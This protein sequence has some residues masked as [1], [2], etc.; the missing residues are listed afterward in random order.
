MEA[1]VGLSQV[2]QSNAQ[3]EILAPIEVKVNQ[4]LR[5]ELSLEE[6]AAELTDPEQW[7]RLNMELMDYSYL[8]FSVCLS[9]AMAIPASSFYQARL[10]GLLRAI[11]RRP[12]PPE[13]K[14]EEPEIW[15]K[16]PDFWMQVSEIS[17]RKGLFENDGESEPASQKMSPSEWANLHSFI[18]NWQASNANAGSE[19]T[20]PGTYFQALQLF[21]HVLE[22]PRKDQTIARNLPAVAAWILSSAGPGLRL[23]CQRNLGLGDREFTRSAPWQDHR[24]GSGLDAS[25]LYR[26]PDTWNQ[27][28]WNFWATRLQEMQGQ[29]EL[30]P[31][32][33]GAARL[34]LE[35]MERMEM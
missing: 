18:A 13:A 15:A 31:E 24:G 1:H 21:R 11:Q 27:E 6:A 17:N 29:Q 2:A 32:A 26:G 16:M 30:G 8:L 23:T 5:D 34:A 28:R 20:S 33:C 4:A 14:E 25:E 22:M 7:A 35:R 19:E 10:M 12:T 3:Y 9:K